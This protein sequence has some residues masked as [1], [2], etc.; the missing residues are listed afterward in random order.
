[1]SI[2]PS[3]PSSYNKLIVHTL[4]TDFRKATKQVETPL[5]QPRKGEVL[6]RNAV[7]GINASD[8]NFTAGKY[9]PNVRPPLDCGF[10]S[11][12]VIVAVGDG[13]TR[14]KVG[15]AVAATSYG[16]FAQYQLHKERTVI[17]IP[18]CDAHFL[19]LLVSGL[20][21]SIA[22][23]RV[24]EMKVVNG[25]EGKVETVLV[26]AAAGGTGLF[27]VQLARAAGHRV[28][29]TC[30]S[31]EKAALL[32]QLGCERVINYKK[33]NLHSVLKKGY[34][35]GIDICYES[36]GGQMFNDCARNLAVKGRLIVIGFV[37]QYADGS[38]WKTAPNSSNAQALSTRSI[39]PLPAILLGKSASVR[40]FF[41]NHYAADFKR[42]MQLLTRLMSEGRIRSFVDPTPFHGLEGIADAID[43]MYSGKNVGKVVVKLWE[44]K[45]GRSNHNDDNKRQPLQSK[46]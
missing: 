28:I 16:A 2:P 44:P 34:P 21:A 11:I 31:D 24:G 3:L 1:M 38:G 43:F 26:T 20:T 13:V 12:G 4:S 27:A 41:L 15:D 6:V 10:E 42:H 45:E 17:P 23:E 25:G 9:L 5:A 40:G 46:L 39:P 33:E 36:V 8:I 7:V 30:S 32:K 29:G 22:L 37:S 18:S 35:N 14:V 19:P